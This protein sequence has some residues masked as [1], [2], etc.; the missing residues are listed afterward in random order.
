[1]PPP[2][3]RHSTLPTPL[4]QGHNSL[5]YTPS[6]LPIRRSIHAES[7]EGVEYR[8]VSVTATAHLNGRPRTSSLRDEVCW[9]R[10]VIPRVEI[11]VELLQF[12]RDEDAID[13]ELEETVPS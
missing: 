4:K 12:G 1:M 8:E 11:E 10:P 5:L 2:N 3:V 7:V 6:Q 13:E 9:P